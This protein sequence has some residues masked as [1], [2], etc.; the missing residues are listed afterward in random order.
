V[1][2]PHRNY[3]ALP[4]LTEGRVG[5]A[6][7]LPAFFGETPLVTSAIAQSRPSFEVNAVLRDLVH[8]EFELCD[9]MHATPT[10]QNGNPI[11]PSSRRLLA[12]ASDDTLVE[13]M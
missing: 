3:T 7:E 13:Q 5:L 8:S 12:L 10:D 4:F 11:T 6:M 9:A 2:Q 1:A